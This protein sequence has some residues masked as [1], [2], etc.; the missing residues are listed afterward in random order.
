MNRIT[1]LGIVA[2]GYLAAFAVAWLA[3]AINSASIP[4]ADAQAASGM[5]AFGDLCLFV[6]VFG[7]C[8]LFPTIAAAWFFLPLR[9]FGKQKD[10]V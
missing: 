10:G 3:V 9:R 5:Y 4:P 8:S 2:G 6:I 7:F 1:K